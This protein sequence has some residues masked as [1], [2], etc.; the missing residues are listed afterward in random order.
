MCCS[1]G[2]EQ[3]LGHDESHAKSEPTR[4]YRSG[5]NVVCFYIGLPCR[6]DKAADGAPAR[7]GNYL[8]F[9]HLIEMLDGLISIDD[10]TK[11]HKFRNPP[12][13]LTFFNAENQ[14]SMSDIR[15][16]TPGSPVMAAIGAD[17]KSMEASTAGVRSRLTAPMSRPTVRRPPA[18]V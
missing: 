11:L 10:G 13:L 12:K 4:A 1:K 16:L 3:R 18:R 5:R 8:T 15:G 14:S 6:F 17:E 7:G 2:E 9:K